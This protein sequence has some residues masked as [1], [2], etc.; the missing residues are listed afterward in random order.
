[1]LGTGRLTIA[2][3][4]GQIF[5]GGDKVWE[6]ELRKCSEERKKKEYCLD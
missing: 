2:R 6:G 5:L 1:M 4:M 3:A